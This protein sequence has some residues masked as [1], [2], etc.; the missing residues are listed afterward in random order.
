V[1]KIF[2]YIFFP[3]FFLGYQFSVHAQED[4]KILLKTEANQKYGPVIQSFP[5]DNNTLTSLIDKAGNYM[6][7]G[8]S[9]NELTILGHNKSVLYPKNKPVSKD[10]KFEVISVD[11]VKELMNL[12]TQDVTIIEYRGNIISLTNGS[13]TL[14]SK[15]ICPPNCP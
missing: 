1:K 4:G 5:A 6:M 9:N 12:G 3:F 8:I 13:Y 7:F 14:I 2:I 15:S 10:E 11:K